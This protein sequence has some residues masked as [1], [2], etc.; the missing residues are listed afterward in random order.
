MYGHSG[1]LWMAWHRATYRFSHIFVN[2]QTF[3]AGHASWQPSWLGLLDSSAGYIGTVCLFP[4]SAMAA[5]RGLLWG[6]EID[7][8]G[9]RF[10]G[11]VPEF[12]DVPKW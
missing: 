4:G 7:P 12:S 3:I 11:L 6:N 10:F 5:G 2:M 8:L 1:N 9:E